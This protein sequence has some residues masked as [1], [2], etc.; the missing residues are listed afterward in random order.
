[1][2]YEAGLPIEVIRQNLGHRDAATTLGYIGPLDAKARRCRQTISFDIRSLNGWLATMP[3]G[4]GS[5]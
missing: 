5:P 3:A 4:G 1:M 2:Q